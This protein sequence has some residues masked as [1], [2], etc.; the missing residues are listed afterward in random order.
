MSKVTTP[1]VTG[2]LVSG[3]S[4]RRVTGARAY[5]SMH[6]LGGAP[7]SAHRPVVAEPKQLRQCLKVAIRRRN[8]LPRRPS[9][10]AA[11]SRS[12]PPGFLPISA[13][14]LPLLRPT[15]RHLPRAQSR[16]GSPPPPPPP[17]RSVAA[18]AAL[19]SSQGAASLEASHTAQ[20][21]L[22][23]P[24]VGPLASG[25]YLEAR[26]FVRLFGKFLPMV[27]LFFMLAFV[28]TILDSLKDTLV[29]TSVGGGAQVIPYLTVYAVLPSSLL[30]LVLYS[31]A[32]QHVSRER[33]FNSIIAT[34]MAFFVTFATVIYPNHHALHLNAFADRLA[35][36]LPAGLD[37]LVG[38]IRN[39]TF[40][41]FFCMSELWGDVCLGLLFW[42]LANDTTSIADA[43]VL[44]PL[45]GLGANVAQALAGFVLKAFAVPGGADAACFV[46][47]MQQLM[48]VSLGV[49][50]LL[51]GLHW[52]INHVE[53][54]KKRAARRAAKAAAAAGLR[55]AADAA[56]RS[57][58]PGETS[59]GS[60]GAASLASA[61]SNG[62]G[63]AHAVASTSSSSSSSSSSIDLGPYNGAGAPA[64]AAHQQQQQARGAQN[65]ASSSSSSISS[66][67]GSDKASASS[68]SSKAAAKKAKPSLREI[69]TVLASST[70]IRCLA[71]MS[72]A[73][74]L[75]TSIMEF[76]WKAHIKLLYP[77]PAQ[78][79]GFLGDVATWQ[80]V[81]T[82][83][84][85][86]LSP[87]LFHQW[88][89]RGVA[90]ATPAMLLWGGSA[91][92]AACFVYQYCF[93]AGHVTT[94]A[95]LASGGAAT[96]MLQGLVLGGALL[97]V[98]TKSAK[99]SMF[100]PAEEMVYI[101]MD[102]EGRTKGKAAIDVVGSQAGKSGGSIVQQAL[103][104]ASG[105]AIV[106]IL[107][108]MFAVF[109][110]MT[111][112]WLRSVDVLSGHANIGDEAASAEAHAT[113]PALVGSRAAAAG[114]A[115]ASML[116]SDDDATASVDGGG[117]VGVV[118]HGGSGP[119][120][121]APPVHFGGGGDDGGDDAAPANGG[122]GEPVPAWAAKT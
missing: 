29:I 16:S 5:S 105:G 60:N 110:A 47:S 39:W 74:G 122:G 95:A 37:G 51:L 67:S 118:G 108:I 31:W 49:T 113:D 1:P 42:G 63:A 100:K 83:A 53:R 18:L 72:L 116:E 41:L 34:F 7:A 96:V 46:S 8:R 50:V 44:Y 14:G 117:G 101:M 40:T 103:L 119:S 26:N 114:G 89:W 59:N 35:A 71:V 87:Y 88:G 30:F 111:R 52:R 27:S 79:T 48:G 20:W 85:M 10:C 9:T 55:G 33:L 32:S 120:H 56:S 98:S 93:A 12:D 11:V 86:V 57:S 97:Y 19:R 69:F 107:P 104:L 76:A 28:N 68:G 94:A 22:Q 21:L 25:V 61:S 66:S 65:G 121:A 43:P 2:P 106:G 62:Y 91:F 4:G 15:P 36:V 99:F 82:C 17:P 45:F 84:L 54:E 64:S 81:V 3:R 13:P 115:E 70:A 58:Q 38:M 92:F 73:Q 23:L 109:F 78:F 75:C 77:S 112:G 24:V 90:A 80:G 6:I 102:E